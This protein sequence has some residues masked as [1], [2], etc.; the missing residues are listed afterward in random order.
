MFDFQFT[1]DVDYETE[2]NAR[3]FE[4]TYASLVARTVAGFVAQM[5]FYPLETIVH[6]LHVQGVRAIIDNTDTGVGV[7][8]INSSVYYTGF[9]SCLQSI[10]E[11]E[12]GSGLYKGVGCVLLKFSLL[13]GGILLA[14]GLAKKFVM[15][16]KTPTWNRETSFHP[17]QRT[18]S[19]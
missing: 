8:P 11:N 16:T 3:L 19:D 17:E 6:R 14:H 4:S 13:Y 15:E 5:V 2:E 7:L 1:L 10:E 9:W 18:T 12:G